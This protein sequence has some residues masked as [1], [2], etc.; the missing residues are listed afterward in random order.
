MKALATS[1]LLALSL[2]SPSEAQSPWNGDYFPNVPLVSHEGK[3]VRFYDDLIEG[4]VVMINFIYTSCPDSC[5]METARMAQV[6]QILGDRMGDDVF[7]YSISIDPEVDTPEVMAQYA[8]RFD[9]GPGW[10]FLTGA[11]ADITLLRKKLGLY[12]EE[13]QA[14]GSKDH[15]LS[16]IVGN[17]ATGRWMKRSPFENPYIIAEQVG[18]WLHNYKLPRK[19]GMAYENAPALRK[20]TKGEELFRNR[21]AA[22]HVVGPGDGLPRPGPNL[23]GVVE[24]RDPA[25]LR[26]WITEPDR[27]LAEKDPL[28]LQLLE[29]YHGVPMPNMRINRVELDF[30]LEFLETETARVLADQARAAEGAPI[31][32]SAG[33]D[34]H[35]DEGEQRAPCCEKDEKMELEDAGPA[36]DEWSE[37][38]TSSP[39]DYGD[40]GLEEASSSSPGAS[41]AEVAPGAPSSAAAPDPVVPLDEVPARPGPAEAGKR[42]SSASLVSIAAGVALG[43]L[44]AMLSRRRA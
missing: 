10:L 41:A 7:M 39:E 1:L 12:L 15:N 21:C 5:P 2:G 37:A 35:Q 23:L 40:W 6:C 4:K 19:A 8:R 14:D 22:C 43:L 26:R 30:L 16:L 25:W 31:L 17:Q 29:A 44:T 42:P 20:I 32:A 3:T 34:E 28:A 27:M 33:E 18:S 9:A 36:D 11:E 13:I 24:A 38:G